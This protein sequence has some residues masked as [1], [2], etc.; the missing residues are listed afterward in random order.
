VT[1]SIKFRVRRGKNDENLIGFQAWMENLMFKG[2]QGSIGNHG[3]WNTLWAKGVM[4][5]DSVVDQEYSD[6]AVSSPASPHVQNGLATMFA[7]SAS[8]SA[9]SAGSGIPAHHFP[10][11][12]FTPPVADSDSFTVVLPSSLF[13][14]MAI[15]TRHLIDEYCWCPFESLYFDY[16]CRLHER[17][18]YQTVTALWSL[19]SGVASQAQADMLV[20]K[21]MA[22]FEMEGGLVCGT[23]VS[24]GPLGPDRPSRQWDYP[25]GWAP[26]QMLA[27]KGLNYYGYNEL[28]SRL[29]YRWCYTVLK[30]FVDFNGVV[31]EKFDV[32]GTTHRVNVEYGNVGTDF[33]FV[34]REGFG[35]MNASFQ[36]SFSRDLL[37]ITQ[38]K[39]NYW[40]F[41]IG[42]TYL[43]K[44]LRRALGTVAPP[45]RLFHRI[46]MKEKIITFDGSAAK[47]ST[48]TGIVSISAPPSTTTLNVELPMGVITPPIAVFT[49][50][51]KPS[52]SPIALSPSVHSLSPILETKELES[53][54]D[55]QPKKEIITTTSITATTT[56]TKTKT[57]I[58]GVGK[59]N[60]FLKDSEEGNRLG[61]V[62]LSAESEY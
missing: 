46:N 50:Q 30:A 6:W 13:G 17:S 57:K 9:S 14:A 21:A 16:D 45:D 32:V 61:E 59:E 47:S 41:K 44:Q 24:R 27:W 51:D 23:E 7:S 39:V 1:F 36:V 49:M 56:A 42:M 20:P 26:H 5:Y 31:P 18:A 15:R 48:E 40:Y 4:V 8:S 10:F 58:V 60:D 3:G 35:W 55:L 11:P 53:T 38:R 62:A 28:A 37:S 25:Y 29:A 19:W 33:K 22:L 43:N 2:V 52:I 12:S 34:V 54:P